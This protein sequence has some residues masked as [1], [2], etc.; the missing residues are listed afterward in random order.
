MF[1]GVDSPQQ[2]SDCGAVGTESWEG[3]RVVSI[4]NPAKPEQLAA[5]A[6]DCGA[7]TQTM[8]PDIENGRVLIYALSYP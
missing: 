8:M 4:E 6:T 5:V 2:T 3:I 7:H 1:V